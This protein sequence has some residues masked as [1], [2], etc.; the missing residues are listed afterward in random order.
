MTKGVVEW[1]ESLHAWCGCDSIVCTVGGGG[2]RRRRRDEVRIFFVERDC[3]LSGPAGEHETRG[4]LCQLW[5]T[6]RA[7]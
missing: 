3:W 6:R 7:E 4:L 1:K 5:I 2:R